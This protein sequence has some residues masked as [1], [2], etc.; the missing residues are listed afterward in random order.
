MNT[1]VTHR[2]VSPFLGR[3]LLATADADEPAMLQALADADAAGV[4][5]PALVVV[6]AQALVVHVDRANP[7]WREEVR[8]G[9]LEGAA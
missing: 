6:L 5:A 3:V 4:D 8:R 7:G 9:L 1:P 2:D